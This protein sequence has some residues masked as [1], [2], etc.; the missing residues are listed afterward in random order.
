LSGSY[1]LSPGRPKGS[2]GFFL[3]GRTSNF[4]ENNGVAIIDFSEEYR[5]YAHQ[6]FPK[7]FSLPIPSKLVNACHV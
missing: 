5:C 4:L 7:K 6:L 2:P 3:L 1:F